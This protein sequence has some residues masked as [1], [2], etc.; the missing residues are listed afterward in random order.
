M[1]RTR[2]VVRT[3][4]GIRLLLMLYLVATAATLV[5]VYAERD[6]DR[7][8]DSEVWTHAVIVF[9]FAVLLLGVVR[10]VGTGNA[11]ALLRLRIISVVIP[12]VSVVLV[13]LPDLFPT[14]MRIEQAGYAVLLTVVAWLAR[15][16][17]LGA[18]VR[19]HARS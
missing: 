16:R 4:R 7:L 3:V 14:W 12:V 9:A 15:S 17:A 19:I 1:D 13:A 11:R 6:D 5:F 2:D 18:V 8:V 10:R